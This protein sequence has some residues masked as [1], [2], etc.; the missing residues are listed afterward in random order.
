[1]KDIANVLAFQAKLLV[2]QI[3]PAVEETPALPRPR[4]KTRQN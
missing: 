3:T 2:D 4:S 1:M